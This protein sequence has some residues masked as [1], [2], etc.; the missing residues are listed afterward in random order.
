MVTVS[1]DEGGQ[2]RPL[3]KFN[4]TWD[5]TSR[6]HRQAG[7]VGAI[8]RLADRLGLISLEAGEADTEQLAI[9]SGNNQLGEGMGLAEQATGP[10]AREIDTGAGIAFAFQRADLDDP[11]GVGD[12]CAR[13]GA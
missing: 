8:Q 5:I 10:A 7:D 12:G 11:A 3:Q 6:R 1:A 13:T 2:R 4:R 9:V